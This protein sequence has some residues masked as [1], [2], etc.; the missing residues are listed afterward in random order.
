MC[1]YLTTDKEMREFEPVEL[2]HFCY[3]S[4]KIYARC[5]LLKWLS[6]TCRLLHQ[7][8]QYGCGLSGN[9]CLRRVVLLFEHHNFVFALL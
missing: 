9:A 8:L 4:G 6:G 5:A 2:T 7:L 1:N 3:Y